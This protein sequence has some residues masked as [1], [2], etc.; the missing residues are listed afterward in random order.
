VFAYVG[1][2]QNLKDLKASADQMKGCTGGE[3][4]GE[5]GG[6]CGG[7]GHPCAPDEED[8]ADPAGGV[9][10]WANSGAGGGDGER[11]G[12]FRSFRF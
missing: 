9:V 5:E 8:I 4:R 6:T 1:S 3:C 10:Q 2:I 7:G 11:K 12:V